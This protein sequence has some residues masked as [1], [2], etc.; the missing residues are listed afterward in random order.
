MGGKKLDRNIDNV[1]FG[2]KLFAA[3]YPSEGFAKEIVGRDVAEC[4]QMLERLYVCKYCF[5]YS[6]EIVASIRHTKTCE[7][8][9]DGDEPMVPGRRI[10][11]HFGADESGTKLDDEDGW[12]VWEVDGEDDPLYCQNLSLFGKLFLDNKSIFFDVANFKYYLL[13]FSSPSTSSRSVVGFFSKEKMSWD[14]NNLA[15]IVVFPP[16]QRKGLG[17]LLIGVSYEISR[18]EKILGGPEKPISKFG[19]GSYKRFWGAAIA[20]FVFEVPD[21]EEVYMNLD[22]LARATWISKEDCLEAL[23]AMGITDKSKKRD[24]AMVID[25]RMVQDWVD[26][27]KTDLVPVINLDGFPEGMFVRESSPEDEEEE[28]SRHDGSGLGRVL[29]GSSGYGSIPVDS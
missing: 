17:T 1:V 29:R 14:N 22:E 10:Y 7:R 28:D 23:K 3:W 13:V 24:G 5:K 19:I 16:W 21:G 26:K 11:E 15:C 2:D 27:S 18:R 4:R 8:R 20:R 25:K 6:K 12:D 9:P